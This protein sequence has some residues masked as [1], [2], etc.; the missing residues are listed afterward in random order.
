MMA[1]TLLLLKEAGCEIQMWN[2]ANGCLGSVTSPPDEVSRMRWQEAQES[3]AIAGATIHPPLFN[4][5]EIFYDK[6]SLARTAAVI[7][8]IRPQIVLTHSPEDYMEDHQNVCRLLVTAIF[9]RGMPHFMTEP[10]TPPYDA[11]ARIYHAAPHGLRD[12][13]ERPF[14]P[15]LLVDVASVIARK[16][17]MLTSHRSQKDWLESSQ[18]MSAYTVEMVSM[19]RS[20]AEFS[21]EFAI[22]E[23]WRRHSHLGFCPEEFDP[24]PQLLKDKVQ[25]CK[26]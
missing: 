18:G 10:P 14:Q 22:A 13:L 1:G 17:Q 11:A 21:G 24:L 19:G 16:E 2:L 7:R 4:D 5:L 8:S 12:S 9:S 15:G 25:P 23:G 26:I 6:A 3:A 20:M